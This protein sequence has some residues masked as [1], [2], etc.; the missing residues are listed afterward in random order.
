MKKYICT[1]VTLFLIFT[2]TVLI[3]CVG[4]GD[5]FDHSE[6]SGISSSTPLSTTSSDNITTPNQSSPPTTTNSA[7]ATTP[8]VTTPKATTAATTTAKVTT[9]QA[10][11]TTTTKPVTTTQQITTSPMTTTKKP[12][13]TTTPV[14]T[15]PVTTAPVTTTP[16]VTEPEPVT[17]TLNIG[18]Y[19]VKHFELVNHN[20]AVIAADILRQNLDIVGIQEVDCNN[21][22]SNYLDEPK[23]IAQHLGW[24][25]AYSKCIDYKGGGYGHCIVSKYPIISY[26]TVMLPSGTSE[27][28][29]FGHAVIDVNGVHVNF[30]NTHADYGHRVNQF[31]TLAEYIA[32][33]D[34][35][36]LTGD[37]NTSDLKDFAPIKNAIC[38]NG[39]KK[40]YL[41][42][43]A[44]N[45]YK[46]I[47]NIVISDY[48]E[49]SNEGVLN[50]IH[51]DHK[52]FYATVKVKVYP[53]K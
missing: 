28:R 51:S 21:S 41:T 12:V 15:K 26:Q 40:T 6:E 11:T 7:A 50:V 49:Y 18:S 17:V 10:P 48:Y 42:A 35:F 24:Y 44:D 2:L 5:T 25:Y 46:S 45:P 33:L 38:I 20:F 32:K 16:P 29:A 53:K 37:F 31:N 23:L 43:P 27:Q 9:T 36:I 13:T 30:L 22:R 3:S 19:N 1:L 14:T 39:H 4:Q 8:A 47:D 34:G 52:M